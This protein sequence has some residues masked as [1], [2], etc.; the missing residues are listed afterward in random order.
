MF[1]HLILGSHFT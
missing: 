1:V